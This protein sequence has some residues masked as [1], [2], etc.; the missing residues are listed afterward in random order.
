MTDPI[1]AAEVRLANFRTS[2]AEAQQAVRDASAALGAAVASGDAKAATE[3]RSGLA[4]AQALHDEL[5]LAIP[6]AERAVEQARAVQQGAERETARTEADRLADLSIA[7][8]Q[9]I[10]DALRA[11]AEAYDAHKQ[12]RGPLGD[13]L[14]AA[15]ESTKADSAAR[16]AGPA[17]ARAIW[18]HAPEVAASLGLDRRG[19]RAY[20]TPFAVV[21]RNTLGGTIEEGEAA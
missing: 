12:L 9:R 21:E 18:H 4:E 11:L 8:S 17:L 20:E 6:H 14:R 3:A 1:Q 13:A 19:A 16:R 15:G 2:A 7:A 5:L 10:D